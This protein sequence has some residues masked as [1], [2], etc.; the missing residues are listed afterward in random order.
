MQLHMRAG[1]TFAVGAIIA[2]TIASAV[3]YRLVRGSSMPLVH[4][5]EVPLMFNG[6]GSA[7]HQY[8]LP[9]GTTLYYD[10]SFPEGF[11]R[12]KVYFNVEGVKLESHDSTEK[13][14]ID[15]LTAFPVDQQQLR[16][17]LKDYPISKAELSLILKSSNISKEE[18]R[19]LL[20]E[21]SK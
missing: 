12:F 14:W 2:A 16:K 3:T 20:T 11:T 7:N 9:E 8:L 15:P 4:K 5:L 21:Y 10:Q 1:L 6:A 17:L 13:F 18:I 19:Q